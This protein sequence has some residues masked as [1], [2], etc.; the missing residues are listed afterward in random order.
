MSSK[1]K[2]P[3]CKNKIDYDDVFC[4]VCG[5]SVKREMVNKDK[6]D[7]VVEPVEKEDKVEENIDKFRIADS[8]SISSYTFLF[9]TSSTMFSSIK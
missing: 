6:V 5:N 3:R 7:E 9:S 4:R 2:C 8:L 1:L